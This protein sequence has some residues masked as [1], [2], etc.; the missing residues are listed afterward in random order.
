MAKEWRKRLA[1][2]VE[3]Q[4]CAIIRFARDE[5]DG[6]AASRRQFRRFTIA[7]N[8]EFVD[9]LKVPTLCIL[10]E[11]HPKGNRAYV[12]LCTNKQAVT[13]LLSRLSFRHGFAITPR[14]EKS[15][16]A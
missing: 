1:R 7:R 6:I 9:R 10:F 8:H 12:A 14:T 3:K 4:P 2:H 5:S 16:A 15:V 13:T 11:I